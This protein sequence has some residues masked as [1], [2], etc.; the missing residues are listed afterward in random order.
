M[1]RSLKHA[2]EL[3]QALTEAEQFVWRRLRNRRFAQYKFR[4]QV[5]LGAYILDFA[6]FDKKLVIELDGG[7]H[8]LQRSYDSERTRWLESQGFRV[9]RFWNHEVLGDWETVE[10]MIWRELQ[11]DPSP[12]APLPQGERGE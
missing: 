12:P 8:T 11:K 1:P 2:R 5:P 6:C 7:Q 4:R 9:V 10:E 3:R